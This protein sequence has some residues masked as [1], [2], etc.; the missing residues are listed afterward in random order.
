MNKQTNQHKKLPLKSDIVFKRVFSNEENNQLLKSL[1]QA[2]LKIQINTVIVTNPELPINLSNGKLGTMDIKA[3]VNQNTIVNIEMQ[4]INEHNIDDRSLSYMVKNSANS[5][6]VSQDY[7]SLAKTISINILDFNF[8]KRNCF[9]NIAHM[10]FEKSTEESFID[11]GYKQETELLTDK[12]EMHFIELPKFRKKKLGTESVLNQWLWLISGKEEKI[13]MAK[14]RID[15][16]QKAMKIIDEMSMD[17]KEWELYESWEKA[18][19]DENSRM[20]SA[21]R[22][23]EK[24]GLKNGEKLGI[25]KEKKEIVK[26]L[27]ELNEDIEKIALITGLTKEEIEQIKIECSK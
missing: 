2:I 7:T 3:K 15:E 8:F 13:K 21:E 25:K 1:L 11:L 26:K 12:L 24:K 16:I 9:H 19:I 22:R 20:K 10:K 14:Y 17:S 23:G 5:L 27:L 18:I 6:K 4:V